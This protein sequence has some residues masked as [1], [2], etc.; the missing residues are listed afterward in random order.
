LLGYKE[1]LATLEDFDANL[2]AN[3]IDVKTENATVGP[4]LTLD[5]VTEKFV[6]EFAAEANKLQDE[7]YREEFKLP[8][9][10]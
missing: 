10:G 3:Q 8:V 7:E 1:A 6:G 9:I 2:L 4:W 5:P